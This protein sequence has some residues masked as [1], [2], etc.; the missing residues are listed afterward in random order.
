MDRRWR[1]GAALVLS[2]VVSLALVMHSQAWK[3]QTEPRGLARLLRNGTE[4]EAAFRIRHA[5]DRS[6]SLAFGAS[7]GFDQAALKRASSSGA[8]ACLACHASVHAR[9]PR[10]RA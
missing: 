3:S 9:A 4:L 6:P 7:R 5:S 8:E 1:V 10:T 2:F